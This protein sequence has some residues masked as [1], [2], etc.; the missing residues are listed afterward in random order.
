MKIGSFEIVEYDEDSGHMIVDMDADTVKS[1]V[2]Y[3]LNQLLREYCE[4]VILDAETER[5]SDETAEELEYGS[6]REQQAAE[7]IQYNDE[8]ISYGTV[9]CRIP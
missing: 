4:Q 8:N 2:S 3:G 1:L 6:Q 5:G 7:G 9:G